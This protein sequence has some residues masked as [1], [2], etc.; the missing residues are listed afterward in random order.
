MLHTRCTLVSIQDERE[1]STAAMA[2]K[3]IQP[4]QSLRTSFLRLGFGALLLALA[5]L[6]GFGQQP[7]VTG[8][9]AGMLGPL[10]V[11]VHIKADASGALSGTLDSVDQGAMGIP[12]AD[13]H[14]DGQTLSFTVPAVHGTWKGT[15]TADGLDGTWDQGAAQPL[16][17]TR[18]TFVAAAKPSAVDGIWLGTLNAGKPL[19]IQLHVKSDSAGHEFCAVDSL[20]QRAMGVECGKVTFAGSDLAF[21][22]PA[23]QG[24]WTGKLS[25]DGN[26]LNGTWTQGGPLALNFTRQAT[27]LGP[28]PIPAPTYDAAMA[29]VAA[30]DLKAVLD[31][32]IAMRSRAASLR[33]RRARG[34]P[35]ALWIMANGTCL[36]MEPRRKTRCSRSAR[37]QRP[38]P[39]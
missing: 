11:R 35:W 36:P 5:V 33:R 25:A 14:L 19:R 12:C 27:A 32:D 16:K 28:K 24:T 38:S 39:A 6:Q 4:M 23:F 37:S 15:V 21:D 34:F 31:K 20:D 8:D 30:A 9:Y 1:D 26:G 22:V 18:D 7:S 10:H 13:F 3:G 29:P 17:L 2:R